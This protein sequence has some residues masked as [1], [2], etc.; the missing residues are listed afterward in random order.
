MLFYERAERA[1]KALAE[2][3]EYTYQEM[4]EIQKRIKAQSKNRK[5]GI[6]IEEEKPRYNSK[7]EKTITDAKEG[8]GLTEITLT[9]FKKQLYPKVKAKAKP[10]TKKTVKKVKEEK[11]PYNPEFVKKILRAEKSKNWI[12]LDTNDI[13]GSLGIKKK[14][15]VKKPK[16]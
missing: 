6:T 12:V 2:Q 7:T 8:K 1:K 10:K 15:P 11:S 3:P 13:W 14:P 5:T 9:E 16:K 4:L